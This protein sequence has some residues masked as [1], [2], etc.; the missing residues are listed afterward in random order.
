MPAA[1][2]IRRRMMKTRMLTILMLAA[3]ALPVAAQ[4]KLPAIPEE[5]PAPEAKLPVAESC[6]GT[7]YLWVDYWVP[8][9]TLYAREYVTKET[10]G[11]WTV[12]YKEEEQTFTETVIRPR[13]V[14]KQVSYCTTEPV[15]TTDPVTGQTTTCMQ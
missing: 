2:P 7:K 15:T 12:K 8:V 6:C 10:C 9:R 4:N 14:T 3:A 1:R 11:T 13:E 5:L